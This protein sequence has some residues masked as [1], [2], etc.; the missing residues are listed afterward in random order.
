MIQILSLPGGNGIF[1]FLD[2][3]QTNFWYIFLFFVA[4]DHYGHFIKKLYLQTGDLK[5]AEK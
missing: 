5:N 3:Q 2:I 4:A 1:L